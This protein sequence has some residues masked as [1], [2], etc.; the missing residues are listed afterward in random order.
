MESDTNPIIV[1][2]G[3]TA[4]GKSA[5]ALKL[6]ETYDGEIIAADS[7]TIYKGMDIGTAKP[8]LQEQQRV[9]HYGL[10]LIT[11]DA[12]FSAAEFQRYTRSVVE[13]IHNRNKLPVIV[14]GTGLYIDGYMYDFEFGKKADPELRKKLNSLSLHE[15]QI[16]AKS[17]DLNPE[18]TDFKNPRHLARAIERDGQNP[19][20]RQNLPA[21][22]LLIGLRVQKEQLD[23]RITKRVDT[24]FNNGLLQEVEELIKQYGEDAPG[25]LAPGYKAVTEH[26]NGRLTLEESKQLFIRNDKALAK[27]QNTWFK[28][29]KDITW[30]ENEH[31]VDNYVRAFLRKFATIET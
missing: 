12:R 9:K 4:S 15:L 11:P 19:A 22:I 16:I 31:Q 21:N 8:T 6:A 7:R 27:R 29:N 23:E 2:V 14:G 20:R 25:L 10:D 13:N 30:C 3:Q 1:I 24:M 26:L 18:Q 5:L 17:R 28:R